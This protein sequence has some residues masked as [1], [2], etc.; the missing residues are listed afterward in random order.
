[1]L[2][3]ST[4]ESLLSI[5][6]MVGYHNDLSLSRVFKRRIGSAP[7]KWRHM[8]KQT[9]SSPPEP[10]RDSGG[11]GINPRAFRVM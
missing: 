7:G 8:M 11:V 4:D 1:M 10:D 2:L 5:A 9:R 6:Q 3:T